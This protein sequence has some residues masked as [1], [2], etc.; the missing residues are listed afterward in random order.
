MSVSAVAW[1]VTS[2]ENCGSFFG[3][4]GITGR[5]PPARPI[6]PYAAMIYPEFQFRTPP[7]SYQVT[8]LSFRLCDE[9][10][11]LRPGKTISPESRS[12]QIQTKSIRARYDADR[13]VALWSIAIC[14]AKEQNRSGI[15]DA[16]RDRLAIRTVETSVRIRAVASLRKFSSKFDTK[17]FS[18]ISG[19]HAGV[20]VTAVV[21]RPATA[22]FVSATHLQVECQ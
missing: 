2:R 12:L 6:H 3:F 5:I 8:L 17:L 11:T 21:A 19:E 9:D 13:Y 22:N 4:T 16:F 14:I 1:R 10:S 7:P 20:Q 18:L 15:H